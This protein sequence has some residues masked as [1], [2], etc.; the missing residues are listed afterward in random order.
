MFGRDIKNTVTV[1]Q[2][3]S[4]VVNSGN[5]KEQFAA[6]PFAEGAIGFGW[7][8]YFSDNRYHFESGL[9]YSMTMIN[10]SGGSGLVPGS[11]FLHGITLQGRFDF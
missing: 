9:L 8:Q 2:V 5:E 11:P 10:T 4:P 6:Y 7:G 3:G 1:V